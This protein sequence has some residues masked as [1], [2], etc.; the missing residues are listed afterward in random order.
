MKT[1][2]FDATATTAYGKTLDTPVTFSVTFDAYENYPEVER[3]HDLFTN[4]EVVDARNSERKQKALAAARSA[5]LD[6]AGIQKPTLEND[7]QLQLQTVYKVYI[8][9]GKSHEEARA[10]ASAA[11]GEE[12][13]S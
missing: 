3:A 10:L 9:K 5:A 8:A 12:W 13:T 2:T 1:I 7:N 6:A 11:I 4:E